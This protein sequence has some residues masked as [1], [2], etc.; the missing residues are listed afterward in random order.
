VQIATILVERYTGRSEAVPS[1]VR[2]D[3]CVAGFP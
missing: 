3:G 2:L 1:P